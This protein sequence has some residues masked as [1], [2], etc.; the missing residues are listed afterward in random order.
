MRN[1]CSIYSHHH[2]YLSCAS[3]MLKHN[4]WYHIFYCSVNRK[5]QTATMG[6]STMTLPWSNLTSMPTPSW[7]STTPSFASCC[8]AVRILLLQRSCMPYI[9]SSV[10][11]PYIKKYIRGQD[12]V[13]LSV[14]AI[15]KL[16]YWVTFGRQ[17]LEDVV[18]KALLLAL[19]TR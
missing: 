7:T 13:V 1:N 5:L 3:V 9:V 19:C 12:P 18:A 14:C 4:V 8:Q 17:S 10:I 16:N 15:F 11:P 6:S 2:W